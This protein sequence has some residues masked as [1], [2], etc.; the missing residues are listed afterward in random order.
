MARDEKDDNKSLLLELEKI[1]RSIFYE[2]GETVTYDCES[3]EK[4]DMAIS[5]N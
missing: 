4:N 2:I 1:L 5:N 3:L